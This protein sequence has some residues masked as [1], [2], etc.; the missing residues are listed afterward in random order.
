MVQ[1]VEPEFAHMILLRSLTG[2]RF[3]DTRL[4]LQQRKKTK[5][6]ILPFVTTY[7]PAV[8]GLK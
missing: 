2:V 7:H 4:A 5:T 1:N 6:K 3:E 8:R